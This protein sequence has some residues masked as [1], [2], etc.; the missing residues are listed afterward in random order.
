MLDDIADN[1]IID[2]ISEAT[3]MAGLAAAV[4]ESVAV[5]EGSRPLGE[6][7]KQVL[8]SMGVAAGSSALVAMLFS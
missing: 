5:M 7:G 3:G 8:A 4:M 6:A 2:R 1:T